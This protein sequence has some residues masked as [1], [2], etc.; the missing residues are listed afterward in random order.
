MTED[1][2]MSADEGA[3][4]GADKGAWNFVPLL[5]VQA[6]ITTWAARDGCPANASTC[7]VAGRG[8]RA[9]CS[10]TQGCATT[11]GGA[12]LSCHWNSTFARR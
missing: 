11:M 10:P 12:T 8:A 3:D 5:S 1:R 2:H 4:E 9:G 7:N 6:T